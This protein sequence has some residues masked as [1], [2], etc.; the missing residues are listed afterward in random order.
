MTGLV[1]DSRGET[2]IGVAIQVVGTDRGTQTDL[3][4]LFSLDGLLPSDSLNFTYVGLEMLTIAVGDQTVINVTLTESTVQLAEVVVVGYGTQTKQSVVGSIV[5]ATGDDIRQRN[6]GTD[7]SN[8]LTGVLPGLVTI[9][10]SGIPGG[11][12]EDDAGTSIYIRGLSTWNGGQPLILVDG[13]E[14]QMSDVDPNQ[15]ES[16]S[17]LKD[18]SATAVFGVKGA[19]GV[20]LIT[21]RRGKLGKP[22]LSYNSTLTATTLSRTY[23]ML[24]SYQGN[25]LKNRAIENE[26]AKN[27]TSWPSYVP[28]KWLQYYQNQQYPELFPDID[29]QDEF[30]NDVAWSQKHSLDISGGTKFVKYFGSLSYLQESDILA[31]KDYGQGYDPDFNY[32]RYN[33]RSNLDFS[34]TPTTTFSVNLAGYFGRQQ[35]PAG[36]K[37]NFWK[38]F[39]GRPPDLYPVRYSDGTWADAAQFDRYENAVYHLNYGGLTNENRSEINTDFILKQDLSFI[40]EG[41]SFT[42]SLSYD[43]RFFS[44]GSN[45]SDDGEVLKWIDPKAVEELLPGMTEEQIQAVYEKYTIYQFPSGFN[46][47]SGYSYVE[48][49][50]NKTT[51]VVRTQESNQLYRSLFYQL[52]M[53]YKRTFGSHNFGGTFLMNRNEKATGTD[54][55]TY[56][57]DWVGRVTY[58]FSSRYF[59]EF[60]GAYNGSEKFSNEYRYGFFPSVALGWLASEEAFFKSLFPIANKF[61]VRYSNG[62]VGND[63]GIR[64]WLYIGNPEVLTRTWQFGAPF[65]NNAYPWRLEGTIANPDIHWETAHKQNVG[66]EI[67]LFNSLIE[68]NAD[69]FWEKRTDMFLRETERNIP[70]LFGADPVGINAGKVN[71]HGFEV[72]AKL[73]KTFSNKLFFSISGML[74]Y[75]KDEVI[76]REDPELAP[77]YQKQAGFQIGQ[78]R[79]LLNQPGL[80]YTWDQIYTGVLPQNNTA[81]MLP[82]DF[83][84]ID[85]N[86]DGQINDFDVVP[87]GYPSRPQ[88]NYG[89]TLTLEYKGLNVMAQFFGVFNINSAQS[90]GEFGLGYTLVRPLHWEEAWSPEDD[91]IEN[92]TYRGLRYLTATNAAPTGT[93]Y[94]WDRSY[95][96]LQNAEIGYRLPSKLTQSFGLSALRV[97]LNGNNLF[98][99]SELKEDRD[100]KDSSD[101]A[102]P[103]TRRYSLGVNVVF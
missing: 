34:V 10:T 92:A 81:F 33:F 45:I 43:N 96:K 77:A 75:A 76:Y 66:V 102:Y 36:D 73:N 42:G 38:G 72:D 21:T 99:I 23:P 39:T 15:V 22:S 86:G 62:I 28:Y 3:D 32:K 24:G 16:L 59:L 27:E 48:Q 90:Y 20:I 68:I 55:L 2:L 44:Y 5:Q 7:L 103:L 13:V 65:P 67:G 71:T 56:R 63:E 100:V 91:R 58:N 88:F 54:F 83:R 57:E 30:A 95:L 80:I 82:G 52:A 11:A 8:T 12:G 26:V 47:A 49:P 97:Y 94:L 87:Y 85:Y 4:G 25:L 35:R 41:L 60:N 14:R 74:A 69:Y 51:E 101:R 40:T 70:I 6:A 37:F 31:T 17:I 79:S 61:K 29:W 89:S 98:M 93:Y 78:S 19:N 18:A 9:R 53:N 64:R 84:Q 50:I 1:K 46:G